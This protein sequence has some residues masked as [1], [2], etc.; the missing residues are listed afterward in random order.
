MIMTLDLALSRLP[1]KGGQSAVED[2][3]LPPGVGLDSLPVL[4]VSNGTERRGSRLGT[5]VAALRGDG[6]LPEL[7]DMK[8]ILSEDAVALHVNLDKMP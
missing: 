4:F 8:K 7:L 3:G 5:S 6:I 1:P 2:T